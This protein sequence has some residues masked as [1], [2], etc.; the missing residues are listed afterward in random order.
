MTAPLPYKMFRL[1]AKAV[2]APVAV[3]ALFLSCPEA[4]R[5][6]VDVL[7]VPTEEA[8]NASWNLE[9][10]K[11]VTLSDNTIV[12]ATGGVV[13]QRGKDILKAD[14]ARYYS[15][16]NWVYLKGNVFVR[17]G[18]DDIQSDEAEFDL[19]SKTG[20][21]TNGHVFMEGPHI[22]FSGSRIVKHWG[23]RYT[24]NKAKV[25]TCD[26]PKPAWSMNAEQA[27][28]EIDGYAQ[29]F[30]STFDVRDTGILYSPFMVLPAKTTRQS[31]LLPPDFGIS[32]KRGFYYTQPYF[33]AIDESHDMTFYGGFMTKIGPLFSVEYRANEFSDQKTWLAATGIYDKDT[34][35]TP[36][37]SRVSEN[38]SLLRTNQERYWLRGMADGFIGA[39]TWRYRSNID[40]V[41][42]Q[43]FL[44]EFNQGPVGFDRTRNSLFRMFGR[45]LQEVDQNRVSAGLISN[46]WER[47]GVV[48]SLRYEQDASLGHGNRPRNQ[49]E[50]VQRLPQLDLFLY[51]G[52]IVPQLPFEIETQFQTGYMYRASGTSGWRT[53]L[54]PRVSLPL[55]L[56]FGSVIGTVGL[57]QTYYGTDRKE[58]TTP[59]AMYVSNPTSPR[60]TGESRTLFDMDI[61]GYTE[62]SR[63]WELDNEDAI[64]LKP[65]NAGQR[66]WTAVR[67]EI[68]PRIRYSRTPH[69]DQE[70]NPFYITDDRILPRDELTYSITN[71]VTRKGSIVSVTGEGDEQEVRRS[72]FYQDLMRWRL[73][74]GYDFREARRNQYLSQ[75][76]RRPFMD[77]LSDFEISPWDWIGYRGKTYFSAYDGEITRHDHDITLRYGGK[78]AWT[79]GMSFRDKYYDYRKQFQYDNWRDIRMTSKIELLHNMLVLNLTPE[80]SVVLD[81]YR[82]MQKGGSMG[83][84]YDQS[85]DIA[86]TAQCY[87]IIGRYRYDGHDKSYSVMVELPGIF[88]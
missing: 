45:D 30:H 68:Q 44:R 85:I 6:A 10:D 38:K 84:T 25:T 78:A 50:L 57:R 1:M 64:P 9:A 88:D 22:Y 59:R 28:V 8:G 24:F 5:A 40:Y 55:D 29:L 69:V 34:V 49:D 61:Q 26:G 17:M 70:K 14:F 56:G 18:K 36:G 27:V 2:I 80:W 15:A 39:S 46:D 53:E 75:Y 73:A 37:T 16:T 77:I 13:L 51:K 67:H 19:H 32:D 20:W 42:D 74:G 72:S 12:E 65:E 66:V 41:S 48:A 63:I 3:L 58:F 52:R 7:M 82:N 79:T 71:I 31:G 33:W 60:Q 86:Y 54:Y 35:N 4:G 87:R 83:K 11:L 76:G 81:D 47:F 62:A 21:L 43:D 23:D